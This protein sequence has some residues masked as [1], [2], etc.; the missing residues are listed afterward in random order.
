MTPKVED[1]IYAGAD[2]NDLTD[3]AIS[4]GMSTL[5]MIAIKKWKQG[6]TTMEEIISMT[7]AD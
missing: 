2:L 1:A 4:E 5:R 3:V 6:V 7:A